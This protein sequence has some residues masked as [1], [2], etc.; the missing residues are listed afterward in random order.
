MERYSRRLVRTGGKCGSEA[1]VRDRERRAI[2]R[3]GDTVGVAADEGAGVLLSHMLLGLFWAH[4][5]VVRLR[6][7]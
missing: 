1:V 7:G 6:A 3:D 2:L 5:D 4:E